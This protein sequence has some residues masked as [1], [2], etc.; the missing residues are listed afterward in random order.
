MFDE[1]LLHEEQVNE[2]LHGYSNF[3]DILFKLKNH[4]AVIFPGIIMHHK[5]FCTNDGKPIAIVFFHGEIEAESLDK[6]NLKAYVFPDEIAELIYT[7]ALE[8]TASEIF[9]L[10]KRICAN[11]S[12]ISR[13]LQGK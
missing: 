5:D 1:K 6:L 3:S 9:M 12:Q 10:K 11:F 4:P 2:E 7:D 13:F 8:Y